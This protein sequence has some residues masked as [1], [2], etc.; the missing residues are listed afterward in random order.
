MR[1]ILRRLIFWALD[2]TPAE[3]AR[4]GM[5]PD[6]DTRTWM[7]RRRAESQARLPHLSQKQAGAPHES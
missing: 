5:R 6:E 1:L 2:P 3:R 7:L 4:M